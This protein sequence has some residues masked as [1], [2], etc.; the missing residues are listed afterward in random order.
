MKDT[1][2]VYASAYTRTLENKMLQKADFEAL[3]SASSYEEALRFLAGKNYQVEAELAH[4]WEE[5]KYACPEG[6]PLHVLLYQND[7]HNLKTILKAVFSDTAYEPLMLEPW[8]FSP[9]EIHR[10][11]TQGRPES[12]PEPFKGPAMEAYQI[13]A[14]DG[15]GQLAE[16]ALDKALFTAMAEIAK[17]SKN[18]FLIGWVDLNIALIN[19]KTALRAGSQSAMLDGGHPLSDAP[20]ESITTLELWCDNQLMAYLRQARQKLF[21]FEPIF[22]FLVGKQFELQAVRMILAGLRLGIPAG[23]LRERLRDSYV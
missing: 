3:L 19:K 6:A 7:F 8:T 18:D 2:F 23:A 14:L 10:A 4:A 22:G 16:I 9:D 1:D 13:L 12:L 15:D 21:G 17:Q 5:V 11:I 20:K